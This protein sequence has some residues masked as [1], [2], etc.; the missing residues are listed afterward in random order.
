MPA[1]QQPYQLNDCT[2]QGAMPQEQLHI[3][4]HGHNDKKQTEHQ[5]LRS[6]V[7]R[8]CP[9]EIKTRD[10]TLKDY[11]PKTTSKPHKKKLPV[12]LPP[13]GDHKVKRLRKTYS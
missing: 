1:P 7:K 2:Q 13:I 12:V 9:T 3:N 5:G 10:T 4:H 8:H 11:N 6:T